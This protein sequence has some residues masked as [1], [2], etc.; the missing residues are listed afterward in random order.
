MDSFLNM[1]WDI[2]GDENSEHLFDTK[3]HT[4]P[5]SYLV[6]PFLVS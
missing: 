3:Y 2:Q 6:V 1:L 5:K 4:S